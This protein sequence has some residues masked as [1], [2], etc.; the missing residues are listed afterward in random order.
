MIYVRPFLQLGY[1]KHATVSQ[2][3]HKPW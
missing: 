3:C 2:R 1:H